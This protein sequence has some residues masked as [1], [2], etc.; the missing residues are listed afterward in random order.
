[1][2]E[3]QT[4]NL[5]VDCR[6]CNQLEDGKCTREGGIC[7]EAQL[8]Q[9]N[10][11][12]EL[13]KVL[14]YSIPDVVGVCLECDALDTEDGKC[15][16]ERGICAN[17]KEDHETSGKALP[18]VFISKSQGKRIA[19]MKG[20]VQKFI[21]A[22]TLV[23]YPEEVER[24]GIMRK[25]LPAFIALSDLLDNDDLDE[26]ISELQQLRADRMEDDK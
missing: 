26:L 20:G 11:G 22:S 14:T 8:E 2:N 7:E 1:M 12:G 13:P 19:L 10:T 6:T 21:D 18:E 23:S 3:K 9:F 4:E 25:F 17:A 5:V 15:H 16:N 24:H